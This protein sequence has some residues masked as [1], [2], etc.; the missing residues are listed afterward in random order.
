MKGFNNQVDLRSFWT[1]FTA[2]HSYLKAM[3]WLMNSRGAS[4]ISLF[5]LDFPVMV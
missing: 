3:N 1:D 2:S 4:H 5:P